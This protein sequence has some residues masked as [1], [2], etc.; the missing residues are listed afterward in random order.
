LV[1]E[2]GLK[3][4]ILIALIALIPVA[5]CDQ[6]LESVKPG[7]VNLDLGDGYKASFTLGDSLEAYDIVVDT[8]NDMEI[9]GVTHYS[10][11]I[12]PVDSNKVLSTVDLNIFQSLQSEP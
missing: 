7:P 2:M 6:T 8:P 3:I 9:I 1:Y 12:H 4:V 11:H 5:T 10:F